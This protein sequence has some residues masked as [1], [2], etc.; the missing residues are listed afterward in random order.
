MIAHTKSNIVQSLIC[1]NLFLEF[2]ETVNGTDLLH[3]EH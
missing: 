3:A 1:K 2:V